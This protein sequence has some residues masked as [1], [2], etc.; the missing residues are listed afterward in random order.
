M[1]VALVI[2][3]ESFSEI[4]VDGGVGEVGN[5]VGGMVVVVDNVVE[6]VDVVVSVVLEER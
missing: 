6:V 5:V 4:M 3:E 1:V 2:C